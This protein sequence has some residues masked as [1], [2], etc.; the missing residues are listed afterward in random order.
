MPANPAAPATVNPTLQ[1]A[2]PRLIAAPLL[3]I[4][5]QIMQM[6][7]SL[8]PNMVLTAGLLRR[9]RQIQLNLQAIFNPLIKQ[10]GGG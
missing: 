10:E 1:T 3:F 8:W 5:Q 2:M 7:G 4:Y 6:S 9:I